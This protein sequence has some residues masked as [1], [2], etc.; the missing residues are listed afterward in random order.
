MTTSPLDVAKPLGVLAGANGPTTDTYRF[1]MTITP[2]AVYGSVALF[3]MELLARAG[4]SIMKKGLV[5]PSVLVAFEH[6][7][8][9]ILAESWPD[10]M[11]HRVF[12]ERVLLNVA[13]D[14]GFDL[15]ELSP[16]EID[17]STVVAHGTHG[18]VVGA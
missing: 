18:Y 3:A 1:M 15:N 16:V 14:M 4:V 2:P 6:D 17:D 12:V 7:G 5:G 8:H 11:A 10:R 9:L 13:V